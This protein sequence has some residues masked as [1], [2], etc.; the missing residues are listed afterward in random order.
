MISNDDV[1]C[2]KR[3]GVVLFAPYQLESIDAY[4]LAFAGKLRRAALFVKAARVYGEVGQQLYDTLLCS[5]VMIPLSN[6]LP[7]KACS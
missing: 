5:S 7:D 3:A 2:R 4:A 6:Y 1:V